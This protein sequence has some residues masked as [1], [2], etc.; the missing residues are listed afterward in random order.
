MIRAKCRR[1]G[2]IIVMIEN[3]KG[4]RIPSDEV[5]S[6]ETIPDRQYS[7]HWKTC[8]KRGGDA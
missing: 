6:T 1:C 5:L 7:S 3:N 2:A 8:G 4:H